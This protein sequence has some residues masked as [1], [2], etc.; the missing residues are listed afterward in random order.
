MTIQL[1]DPTQLIFC[2]NAQVLFTFHANEFYNLFIANNYITQ[3][4][5]SYLSCSKETKKKG[6]FSTN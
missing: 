4:V 3:Q 5:H 1:A 6:T 2:L